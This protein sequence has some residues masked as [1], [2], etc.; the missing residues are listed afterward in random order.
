[1]GLFEVPRMLVRFH[2]YLR[3]PFLPPINRNPSVTARVL[4]YAGDF[5]FGQLVFHGLISVSHIRILFESLRELVPLQGS[6]GDSIA[7]ILA[8]YTLTTIIR[9]YTSLFLGV[10][11]FQWLV[12]M[13]SGAHGF[14][15]RLCAGAR[16]GIEFVLLPFFIFMVPVFSEK[17]SMIERLSTALLKK[18]KGF[19]GLMGV[20]ARPLVVVFIF[21]SLFA[22]LLR[23]LAIIEGV[24]VEFSEISKAK[25]DNN[26]DFSKFR[27]FPSNYFGFTTFGD[28][29]G[30]RFVLLPQ[31]EV[32]KEGEKT[33]VRP[34]LGIFDSKNES[35]GFLKK[36]SRIDWRRLAEVARRGNP[37]FYSSYPFLAGEL[38]QSELKTFSERALIELEE[39]IISSL[40][41]SFRNVTR[42][43]M[44]H[45]PFLGGYV[46]LRQALIGLLDVGAVPRSDTV[47]LGDRKFL[48]FRQLF[49]E[50]T[51]IEKKYREILIPLSETKG[52]ILRY[53]WDAN[54]D[55]AI[56][57]RDFASSFFA[58]AKW[59]QPKESN[60]DTNEMSA[61][62]LIDY[63][64]D[65]SID[66]KQKALVQEFA[67]RWFFEKSRFALI[68]EK[69]QLIAWLSISMNRVYL[70]TQSYSEYQKLGKM[71]L[72]LRHALEI[73]DIE[74]FNL[75]DPRE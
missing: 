66:E 35:L 49:E 39:L 41:L 9:F 3:S 71:F 37:F 10:S 27:F 2:D 19:R 24:N 55:S 15:G 22:P 74:F 1:M 53:E 4:A 47:N 54:L 70:V 23:N 7:T 61:L 34:Y 73:K 72:M 38:N 32:T 29:E 42:H 64:L 43:V 62:S 63:L 5:S 46:D 40:E 57:R 36:E 58:Q 68:N 8:I 69:K 12:G 18:N 59:S 16:V 50:V 21:L 6:G 45:G 56:S 13:S 26:V 14:S 25:I 60:F 31:Y 52:D 48:R 17:P 28:L 51:T 65:Q 44:K 67:Y 20:L 11:L 75:D 33:R 30:D